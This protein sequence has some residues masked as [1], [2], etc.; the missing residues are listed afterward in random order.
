MSEPVTTLLT[1]LALLQAKHFIFDFVVQ[2]VY[3]R[4]NKG[5]YGH[6]GGILHA[7][8]HA[9]GSLPAILLCGTSTILTVALV[10][11]EFIVHYHA[12]WLKERVMKTTGWKADNDGYWIA[13]GADQLVHHLTYTAMLWAIFAA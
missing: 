12:D 4:R 11:G 3:Q 9:F 8:L 10:I 7:G 5:T 6:P 2:T 1:A 13:L